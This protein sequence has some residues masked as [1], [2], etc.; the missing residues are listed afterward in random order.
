MD[1]GLSLSVSGSWLLRVFILL[2]GCTKN[3]EEHEY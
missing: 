1:W 2:A 3:F